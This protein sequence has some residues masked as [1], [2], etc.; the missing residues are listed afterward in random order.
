MPFFE[1]DG[2]WGYI[3]YVKMLMYHV[4]SEAEVRRVKPWRAN[5]DARDTDI[6]LDE[7]KISAMLEVALQAS[8][9]SVSY[10]G[11][12]TLAAYET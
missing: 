1:I 4:H 12:G 10:S 3:G 11:S 2:C 8:D 5:K 7:A 9:Q 6:V